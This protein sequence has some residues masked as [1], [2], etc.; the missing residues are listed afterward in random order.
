MLRVFSRHGS[1]RPSCSTSHT[2][3][4]M[5][6][7]VMIL[8]LLIHASRS[9]HVPLSPSPVPC[10]RAS[11]LAITPLPVSVLSM[12]EILLARVLVMMVLLCLAWVGLSR[13]C[14]C[15]GVLCWGGPGDRRVQV[16]ASGHGAASAISG[17]KKTETAH[18]RAR[19]RESYNAPCRNK[20]HGQ[21]GCAVQFYTRVGR[22]QPTTAGRPRVYQQGARHTQR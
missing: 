14:F 18:Q 9:I 6:C 21:R 2:L 8:L 5:R 17:G 22:Q 3:F 16:G 15:V 12:S 7:P 19:M 10:A 20:T 1:P 13:Y 11:C 4:P